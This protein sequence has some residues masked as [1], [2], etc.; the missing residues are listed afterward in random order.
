LWSDECWNGV[1]EMAVYL[2]VDVNDF[3]KIAQQYE[4]VL[5]LKNTLI[6]TKY[7]GQRFIED[8]IEPILLMKKLLGEY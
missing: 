3:I 1:N 7:D 2:S 4:G 8:Y 5:S 6:F